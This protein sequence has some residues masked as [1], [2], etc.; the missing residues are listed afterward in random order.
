M[1]IFPSLD[2][3]KKLSKDYNLIPVYTEILADLETPLSA[4][5]K[6]DR[7]NHSF[8]LE[9]V[10]GGENVGRYSFLGSEPSLIF[11]SKGNKFK[12]IEDGKYLAK[13]G[14]TENPLNELREIFKKYKTYCPEDLPPFFGGAVG[15]L[16]YDTVRL[17]ENLP[18]TLGDELNIDDIVLIFTD[19]IIIFDHAMH[20]MKIVHNLYTEKDSDL[21]KLYTRAIQNIKY[22]VKELSSPLSVPKNSSKK[23]IE[24]KSNV[25]EKEFSDIVEKAKEY[26]KAGDVFQVVLSRRFSADISGIEKINFYRALRSVNPSPYMFYLHLD[27]CYVIGSS[28][29]TLV[30][31]AWG[32]ATLRPIAGTRRR[33]KNP[34]D[35][36]KMEKELLA[37]EKEVAEHVMLIDLG[38]NDIGRVCKFASVKLT[39]KMIIEK[40]SHVMHIV[41]TVEGELLDDKDAL[42][43]FAA[44]FPAGTLTGAP[45]IRSMQIIEELEKTKR[46]VYGGAVGY[47]SYNGNMDVCIAIRTALVKDNTIYIQAGGGIVYDSKPSLEWL[48][49]KNKSE[50]LK[51]ALEIASE[52]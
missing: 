41:S 16:S 27:D 29:E 50:A 11:K 32:K 42:D 1:K 3:V 49:T 24:L 26:I 5:L 13:E 14:E 51:K 15:Y 22:V 23:K 28:P 45:K 35:E 52:M 4:F 46:G 10:E 17:F 18:D 21:E 9:S 40:Y 36:I 6:I 8:L 2:D 44:T 25:S 38:R 31:E 12:I 34:E 19:S 30:K 7:G 48:E 33:G 43:L 39:E 20:K 47:F 37:D